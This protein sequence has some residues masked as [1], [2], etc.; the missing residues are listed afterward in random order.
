MSVFDNSVY[1]ASRLSMRLT[2]AIRTH[3][4]EVS[5]SLSQSLLILRHLFSHANVRSTA[6]RLGRTVNP[7]SP[8]GRSRFRA[9]QPAFPRTQ[10]R[11]LPRVSSVRPYQT[12][13]RKPTR[14]LL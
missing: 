14:Q 3:A 8:F 13:T 10:V 2:I 7:R 6:Q 9:A 12:Q 4:S 5:I 1:A 11:Q